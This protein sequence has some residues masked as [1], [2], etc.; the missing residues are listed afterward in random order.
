[1]WK[2]GFIG[3]CL[4]VLG[5]QAALADIKISPLR[6][7]L[8]PDAPVASFEVSNPSGRVFEGRASWIDMSAT[9][10]GYAPALAED[11]ISLSAAPYLIVSPAHFRLKP[12]DR[13]TINVSIRQGARP[14]KG[15]RRSHLLIEAGASRTPIR[16]AGGGLPVDIELGVSAPVLLRNGGKAKAKLSD[17][18][19]LRD[20]DGLLLLSTYVVPQGNLSSY[21]RLSVAFTPSK[22]SKPAPKRTQTLG[23]R[24]NV[25][26]FI[27]AEKRSVEIPLGFVSLGPGKLTLSYEGEAE[28][29]GQVFDSRTYDVE[30]PAE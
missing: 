14:P 21:G 17:T 8:T 28:F 13:T 9:E 22:T 3:F 24:R 30:P 6:L 19:L 12:G 26:G 7:V 5:V 25:N 11:R 1:M 20:K 16:K 4:C 15:E 10:T 18:K 29:K 27:D 2:T 23:E